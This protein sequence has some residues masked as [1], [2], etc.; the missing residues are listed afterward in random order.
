MQPVNQASKLECSALDRS[1]IQPIDVLVRAG[2]FMY[3]YSYANLSPDQFSLA[4]FKKLEASVIMLVRH[5]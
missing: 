5:P 1:A 3:N 4:A 2:I